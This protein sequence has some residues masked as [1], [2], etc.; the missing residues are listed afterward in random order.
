MRILPQL[1]K[2]DITKSDWTVMGKMEFQKYILGWDLYVTISLN[3]KD[4]LG[5]VSGKTRMIKKW[6]Y[7]VS[8]SKTMM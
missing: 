6:K 3:Q 5:T 7:V 2:G 4:C 8:N 1:V